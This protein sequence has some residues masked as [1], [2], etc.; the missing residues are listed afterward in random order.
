MPTVDGETFDYTPEGRQQAQ[1]ARR[2][3]ASQDTRRPA[4]EQTTGPRRRLHSTPITPPPTQATALPSAA[5][6][7]PPGPTSGMPTEAQIKQ[8]L[9][10]VP[11]SEGTPRQEPRPDPGQTHPDLFPNPLPDEIEQLLRSKL[12]GTP[13]R[14]RGR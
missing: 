2:R 4:F 3:S 1:R 9:S 11:G 12:L 13:T 10:S 6:T 5:P 14:R 7:T 8:L